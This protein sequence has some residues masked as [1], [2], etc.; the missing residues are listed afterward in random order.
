VTRHQEPGSRRNLIGLKVSDDMR[1]LIDAQRGEVPVQDYL[2][3]L[4]SNAPYPAHW[5]DWEQRAREAERK[6]ELMREVLDSP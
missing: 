1:A 4:V 2:R 6:L 5:E 3:A